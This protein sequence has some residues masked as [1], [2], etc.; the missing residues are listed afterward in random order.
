L[1]RN[2]VYYEGGFN[3]KYGC[4]LMAVLLF[5]S[6]AVHAGALLPARLQPVVAGVSGMAVPTLA[7]APLQAAGLAQLSALPGLDAPM[8]PKADNWLEYNLNQ[9]PADLTAWTNDRVVR[10]QTA[11]T[12]LSTAATTLPNL[13]AGLGEFANYAGNLLD[14]GNG[15][16][17]LVVKGPPPRPLL[18]SELDSGQ[19]YWIGHNI[20]VWPD[21]VADYIADDLIGQSLV[22]FAV[23]MYDGYW[24]LQYPEYVSYYGPQ[25][26]NSLGN[27]ATGLV[28]KGP[29]P[30]PLLP[31][32]AAP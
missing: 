31:G 27:G 23:A 22:D 4:S 7:A 2:R 10:V 15:A 9:Y 25:F 20:H 12:M 13:N 30:R 21:Q 26:L 28:V 5:G 32:E 29:P 24:V 3:M 17:G 19:N 16:T 1:R 11:G 8:Q 14:V 6:T 18:P